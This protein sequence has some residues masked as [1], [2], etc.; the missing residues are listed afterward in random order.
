M[1][2]TTQNISRIARR[3]TPHL[4]IA[5]QEPL[6]VK[7]TKLFYG[8]LND[9]YAGLWLGIVHNFSFNKLLDIFFINRF[10]RVIFPAKQ[11]VVPWHPRPVGI[12]PSTLRNQRIWTIK[13]HFA[14]SRGGPSGDDEASS[15][16]ICFALQMVLKPH[17]EHCVLETTT[18]SSI[19]TV[20]PRIVE[21][22]CQITFAAL[23]VTDFLSSQPFLIPIIYFRQK[24]STHPKTW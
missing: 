11:K 22:I 13:S 15:H 17:N 9:L 6:R 16:P 24:R 20:D 18:V 10:I 19:D 23:V 5:A 2:L 1:L 12:L 14:T 21:G 7:R 4:H 8:S 3:K